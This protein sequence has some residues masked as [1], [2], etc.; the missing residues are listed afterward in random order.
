[1]LHNKLIVNTNRLLMRHLKVLYV[2][3]KITIIRKFSQVKIKKYYF[4]LKTEYNLK[5]KRK[6]RWGARPQDETVGTRLLTGCL[7]IFLGITLHLQGF[8]GTYHIPEEFDSQ[9]CNA[10]HSNMFSCVHVFSSWCKPRDKVMK[11]TRLMTVSQW[12]KT[13]IGH[14]GRLQYRRVLMD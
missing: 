4:R 1:M 5:A 13:N 12:T 14:Y 8:K 11:R 6:K 2:V 7:I 10:L 3:I 9:Y